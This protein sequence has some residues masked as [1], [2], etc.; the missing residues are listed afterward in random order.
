MN[1]PSHSANEPEGLREDTA[2][3]AAEARYRMLFDYA[4][5][6]IVIADPRSYYLDANASM[7]RMLG[8]TKDEFIGLHASDIVAPAEVPHIGEALRSLEGESHHHEREWIF[9][10]KDGST[11]SAEVTVS[12]M[13]G[14]NY[15]GIIRDST[16]RKRHDARL[17]RL[18]DSN[19]QGVMFW[20]TRGDVTSANGA[21]LDIIGYGRDDLDA[22]TIKWTA[23]T[24]PEYAEADRRA[25]AEVAARSVCTPYEKE[26][27]RRDGSR[28]AVLIGAASF[29]DDSDEGVCFV[30]DLS[31]RKRLEQQLLRAQRMESIGTLAGGIAHDLNNVLSPILGATSLLRS[32]TAGPTEQ[33]LVGLIESGA[34]HGA[35]LIKQLLAFARGADGLH[36]PVPLPRL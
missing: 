25:L 20:N 9:T 27:I 13:P 5:E 19:A 35:A 14:G 24:P 10:R 28:V 23:I 15:L 32:S 16:E 2:H 29:Q 30:L 17:R 12:Q 34:E 22:G 4:P 21:F 3:R 11:F 33:E 6:G 31:E 26:F 7:C 1:S 8:Y 18:V 36:L